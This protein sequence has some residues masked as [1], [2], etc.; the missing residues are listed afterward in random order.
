M[1]EHKLTPNQVDNDSS[2]DNGF[3][4]SIDLS[5]FNLLDELNAEATSFSEKAASGLLSKR[6]RFPVEIFPSTVQEI[7]AS[8]NENLNYPVDFIAASLLYAISVAIGNT[9]CV[10]L[11]TGFQQ[12]AVLYLAIVAPRRNCQK[13][14]VEF[15]TQAHRGYG[16]KN[17]SAIHRT[18]TAIRASFE[19]LKT[20]KRQTSG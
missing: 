16:Q 1:R 11:K 14:P 19:P 4:P 9:Y 5:P 15:C 7:I 6:N 13:S 2:K 12:S 17:I 3:N 18:K 10:E 20:R 8:T